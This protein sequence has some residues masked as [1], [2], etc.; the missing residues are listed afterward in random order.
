M[1]EYQ[2]PYSV[3]WFEGCGFDIDSCTAEFHYSFDGALE[4]TERVQFE[5]PTEPY[6]RAVLGRCLSLAF[7]VAGTS[8]YKCYPT[9]QVKFRDA[10]ISILDAKLLNA[11][12]RDGLS[13][14]VFENG[15]NPDMMPEFSGSDEDV[16]PLPY[17]GAGVLVMQ[18]GGK[19]SLLLAQLLNETHLPYRTCHISANGAV[20]TVITELN[21]QPPRVIRRTIDNE[22]LQL[23]A[24]SEALNGHVPVTYITMS[25]A[26]VDAVLHGENTVLAAIGQEG[27]E[28]HEQIGTFRVNHQ[29]SKT[30]EAEQ[31][32]SWYV[33][34]AISPALN[35]GSPLRPFSELRIAELFTI[36]AWERFGHA[37]SS[38]NVANYKQSVDNSQLRWCGVCPKCANSYLLFVPFVDP[39]ELRG[40]FGGK[41]LF[42][43]A[44]LEQTF[45]GLLG[46]DGVMKP[47]ECVGDIAELRTAYK[48][49]AERWGDRAGSLP[50]A[51]VEEQGRFNYQ[52]PRERQPWTQQ[53]IR[54]PEA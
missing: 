14:F 8:Y 47:F 5:K 38:C 18:S 33:Q 45:K 7:L 2:S 23:A 42:A 36:K 21:G 37:F 39:D 54:I 15:L 29:W 32:F 27:N 12:Y 9:S 26:L 49:A 52:V 11:V 1:N 48:L 43:D 31:L 51:V 28:A 30:W 4:F 10:A 22:K 19:D 17:R 13:Q 41:D 46:I 24:V 6:D 16:Q 44:D 20:P 50:F 53:F 35:V 3:F 25:Y 34:A 40:L